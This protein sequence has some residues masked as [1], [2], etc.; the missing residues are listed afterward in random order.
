MN[1]NTARLLLTSLLCLVI[2][3][4]LFVGYFATRS[5]SLSPVQP[6]AAAGEPV[7][8]I[9]GYR[10][11]T[12]VNAEPQLM[13]DRVATLCAPITALRVANNP[14]QNK[15]LTVYVNE[16]GRNAMLGQLRPVFPEGS[17]IVKEKLAK[18]TSQTPELMT[19][20]IKRGK[21]FNPGSGDWEYMVVDGSGTKVLDQGKLKD[22]QACHELN[23]GTGYVF[24]TY[25][26]D[27]G[28]KRLK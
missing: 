23:A 28:Y 7:K 18:K 10:S 12:K 4:G 14:H 5:Y 11:W 9:A 2:V 3:I 19:V 13:P 25:L 17:V 6:V 1:R 15:Y 22:C 27:E 16:L 26:S 20:M 21:G 24:R 8:E